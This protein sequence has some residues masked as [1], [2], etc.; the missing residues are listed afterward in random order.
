MSSVTTPQ[1]LE[2]LSNKTK[3]L[4]DKIAV[5]RELIS[6]KKEQGEK[7]ALVQAIK[8]GLLDLFYMLGRV[9][10]FFLLLPVPSFLDE[11]QMFEDWL[12]D[13]QL[14]VNECFENP[15]TKADVQASM[16]RLQVSK[17]WDFPYSWI[18]FQCSSSTKINTV[19]CIRLD[20]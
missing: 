4:K 9:V 17:P 8:G 13:A 16:Q 20:I 19:S 12:Q 18:F 2:E 5:T 6:Q 14:A 3:R 7:S 1:A 15:E 11:C 10:F